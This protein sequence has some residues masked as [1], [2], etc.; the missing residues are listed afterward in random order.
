MMTSIC[1]DLLNGIQVLE[2]QLSDVHGQQIWNEKW[3]AVNILSAAKHLVH[4]FGLSRVYPISFAEPI[5]HI[6]SPTD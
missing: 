3:K 1:T 6:M 2:V 5:Y 4:Y